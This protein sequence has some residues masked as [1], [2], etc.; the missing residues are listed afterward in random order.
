MHHLAKYY[1]L[2]DTARKMPQDAPGKKICQTQAET[3]FL[4]VVR[5]SPLLVNDFNFKNVRIRN[6]RANVTLDIYLYHVLNFAKTKMQKPEIAAKLQAAGMV[7]P[8]QPPPAPAPMKPAIPAPQP[9]P[10]PMKPAI[11]APQPAAPVKPQD[12]R[13]ITQRL[14]NAIEQ[15]DD[16]FTIEMKDA[17]VES[18]RKGRFFLANVFVRRDEA[19]YRQRI[20]QIFNESGFKPITKL[21]RGDS[22][23]F[24]ENQFFGI[25]SSAFDEKMFFDHFCRLRHRYPCI[26]MT[27]LNQGLPVFSSMFALNIH[28]VSRKG[29]IYYIWSPKR[30]GGNYSLIHKF[31]LGVMPTRADEIRFSRFRADSPANG[32]PV[33]SRNVMINRGRRFVLRQTSDK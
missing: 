32:T 16:I 8:A 7:Q 24:F 4:H 1:F 10:A 15:I 14:I 28:L 27:V 18:N 33:F 29:T 20:I 30:F 25:P 9:A 5:I 19:A 3:I 31:R 21:R 23:I 6:S 13:Q 2:A 17:S 11:P 12:P 26:D 22:C